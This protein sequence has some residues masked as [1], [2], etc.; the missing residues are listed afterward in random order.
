MNKSSIR[1]ILMPVFLILGFFSTTDNLHAQ[2]RTF[3]GADLSYNSIFGG[4]DGETML[5]SGD[6]N[7]LVPS[8]QGG[9]GYGITFG[10]VNDDD[11]W[12]FGFKYLRSW[13]DASYLEESLGKANYNLIGFPE[14]T[15]FFPGE[16][17]NTHNGR[18][19]SQFYLTSGFDLGWLKVK[20]GFLSSSGEASDATYLWI[21][22]P[23][24]IGLVL[25]PGKRVSIN[26][27]MAYRLATVSKAKKAGLAEAELG[28]ED[29]LGIG[30][31][32]FDIGV[33]VPLKE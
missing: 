1:K 12:W 28:L 5:V 17:P 6:E 7:L 26:L 14:F 33:F 32:V 22:L 18:P 8:L 30:G 19:F 24:G 31:L 13:F 16:W 25:N 21:G 11:R 10:I 23:V 29:N 9:L 15:W 2:I 27:G 20:K 3:I 4:F